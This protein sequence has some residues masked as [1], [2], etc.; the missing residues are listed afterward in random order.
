MNKRPWR[1]LLSGTP[2]RNSKVTPRSG[3]APFS[4]A[5]HTAPGF[6]SAPPPGHMPLPAG[7]STPPAT[8]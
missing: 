1:T 7:Q 6:G 3:Q 5:G 4:G 8:P 2:V